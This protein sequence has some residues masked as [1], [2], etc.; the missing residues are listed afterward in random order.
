[1]LVDGESFPAV[2][3][4]GA[5][6]SRGAIKHVLHN[7]K[8]IKPPLNSD[9]FDIAATFAR[10]EGN[11][12][13]PQRRLERLQKAFKQNFG[14]RRTP[15]MEEAF[16]LLYVTKDFPE[17]YRVGPGR[18]PL[19][20]D[21]REI[22]DFLRLLF[23]ILTALDRGNNLETGYDRLA[24]SLTRGDVLLTLNYDTMLDSA[25]HRRGWDPRDGY[26]INGDQR[27][28]GW[29]A[30]SLPDRDAHLAVDLIKLHGSANWFVRGSTSNLKKVF[31][32]K[33]VRITAPRENEIGRHIRQIVP[34]I[35]GKI[36]EHAHWHA[37]W[38]RAFRALCE[39]R[40]LVVVGCSLIDTDFHLRA[41]LSRVVKT[42][43]ANNDKF[44]R[45]YLVDKAKVRSKWQ[46]VFKACHHRVVVYPTFEQFL[47]REIE[48]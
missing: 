16:S 15:T 28:I 13:A 48:Q 36:F 38:T 30:I 32:S 9:F 35:Y 14:L 43:K 12:S 46:S 7:Q 5:G 19:A 23:P 22:D 40:I 3:I 41:L 2:F 47:K 11:N 4:L 10:A 24:G 6:A 37:L 20:G 17:I 42:R 33:P 26:T 39:A 34:P 25:L 29:K 8:R 27:K 18:R 1:M 44:L 31:S 45:I 21:S